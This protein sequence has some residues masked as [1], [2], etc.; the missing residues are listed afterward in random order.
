MRLSLYLHS[1]IEN[2]ENS[3]E[4]K[5][6]NIIMVILRYALISHR[7]FDSYLCLYTDIR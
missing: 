3:G 4:K 5:K 6:R 1:K 7:C 2:M